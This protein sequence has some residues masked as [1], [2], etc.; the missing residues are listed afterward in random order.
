MKENVVIFS[1]GGKGRKGCFH[2]GCDRESL[3]RCH[4]NA[5][6]IFISALK[7]FR[8]L[9]G[10]FNILHSIALPLMNV[11]KYLGRTIEV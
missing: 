1:N 4:R 10:I 3:E 8:F 7:N 2:G 9:W 6:N 5:F 11:A